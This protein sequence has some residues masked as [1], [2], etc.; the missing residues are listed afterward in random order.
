MGIDPIYSEAAARSEGGTLSEGWRNYGSLS[1]MALASFGQSSL[2]LGTGIA[3]TGAGVAD[4]F[5]DTETQDA[6]FKNVRQLNNAR[7]RLLSSE[8]VGLAGNIWS[9]LWGLAPHVAAAAINPLAPAITLGVSQLPT[10]LDLMNKG[11]DTET[12]GT[13]AGVS[14]A[15]SAVQALLP[16]AGTTLAKTAK[17]AAGSVGLGIAE[18]KTLREILKY[19]GYI[20]QAQMFD[21]FDKHALPIDTVMA[22]TFGALGMRQFKKL[23]QAFEESRTGAAIDIQKIIDDKEVM[24]YINSR[25][26]SDDL[27]SLNPEAKD[28]YTLLKSYQDMIKSIPFDYKAPGA[29]QKHMD[30]LYKALDDIADG[31]PVDVSGIIKEELS[32]T[33]TNKPL[34]NEITKIVTENTKE[35]NK[36]AEQQILPNMA[37]ESHADILFEK[38]GVVSGGE[39][40]QGRPGRQ[41]RKVTEE[42]ATEPSAKAAPTEEGKKSY[43]P[44]DRVLEESGEAIL[45]NKPDITITEDLESGTKTGKA[46]DVIAEYK[47]AIDREAAKKELYT[48]AIRCLIKGG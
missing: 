31:K 29:L 11:V 4:L 23:R 14:M 46:A 18:R 39:E 37:G 8:D 16:V 22:L 20:N 25:E 33:Q 24:D 7:Q 43:L 19:G 28:A 40:M 41:G 45:K 6:L 13:V 42:A 27:R 3:L 35:S 10:G 21:P 17:L 32:N 9:A 12:A 38:K 44:N 48:Q 26:F 30:A 47:A 15:T 2:S 5:G 36:K 34:D 1:D